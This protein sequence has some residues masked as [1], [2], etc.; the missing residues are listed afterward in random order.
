[1]YVSTK[2]VCLW[3]VLVYSK[4]VWGGNVQGEAVNKTL[5]V[6]FSIPWTQGWT[7]GSRAGAAIIVGIEEIKRRQILPG[8][9]IEWVWRDS[10]CNPMQ[11]IQMIVDMWSSVVVRMTILFQPKASARLLYTGAKEGQVVST[12]VKVG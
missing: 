3:L 6:A 9:E 7:V 10:L 12:L 11:G 4:Y 2:A 5:N 1:M 8:Y